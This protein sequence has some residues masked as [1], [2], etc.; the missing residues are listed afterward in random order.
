MGLPKAPEDV[1]GFKYLPEWAILIRI[2]NSKIECPIDKGIGHIE[3]KDR[4][5]LQY[6]YAY[7]VRNSYYL[8]HLWILSVF[9][10][11]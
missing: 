2:T 11:Y 7:F 9:V 5:D 1:S 3:G 4:C 8:E 10:R 6:A